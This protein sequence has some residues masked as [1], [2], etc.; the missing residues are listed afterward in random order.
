MAINQ[1]FPG[2]RIMLLVA[3]LLLACAAPAL[4]HPGNLTCQSAQ[5]DTYVEVKANFERSPNTL[6]T[7]LKLADLLI[8]DGCFDDAL[9]LLEEGEALH[10][11]SNE[12]QTRLRTTR[13]MLS[14]QQYFEGLE[15]A[16]QAAKLSRLLLRCN[17]LADIAACDEAIVLKPKDVDVLIAKGDA[18]T[19]AKRPAEAVAAYSR[20][21]EL[22]P[23]NADVTSKIAAAQAQRQTFFAACQREN[24]DAG[25]QACD[26][27]LLRG[28]DDEF[29]IHKRKAILLQAANQPS[30]ALNAYIAANQLRHDDKSVALGIVALSESS[31]RKDAVTLAARG[32]ALLALGRATDALAPLRQALALAPGLMEAKSQLI[33]AE[34]LAAAEARRVAAAQAAKASDEQKPASPG[35]SDATGKKRYSNQAPPTQSN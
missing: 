34:R 18:L 33:K 17:K 6:D 35:Q 27:A 15:R 5:K 22:A 11:R 32:S 1:N 8:A 10:P 14:E 4:A 2:T 29:A 26:A 28:A 31:S 23:T 25:L 3:A 24:G 21:A 30:L 19:Q 7:R 9:H 20:A 16:E 12:L 13:S